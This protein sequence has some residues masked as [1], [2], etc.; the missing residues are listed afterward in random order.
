MNVIMT[1]YRLWLIAV[2]NRID[3]YYLLIR[4]FVNASFRMLAQNE[5]ED[6]IVTEYNAILTEQGGP[7]W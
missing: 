7:L 6:A 2:L 5:W 4:R 3:K 1:P